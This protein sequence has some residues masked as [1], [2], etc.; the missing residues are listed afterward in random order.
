M[1]EPFG[2][3]GECDQTQREAI[4]VVNTRNFILLFAIAGAT[5]DA[6]GALVAADTDRQ[7]ALENRVAPLSLAQNTGRNS[8]PTGD[9]STSRK[10]TKVDRDRPSDGRVKVVP[11]PPVVEPGLPIEPAPPIEGGPPVAPGPPTAVP[12]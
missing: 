2:D 7:M 9:E 6:P 11:V 4:A 8:V 1:L 3:C 10:A 12:F 5:L